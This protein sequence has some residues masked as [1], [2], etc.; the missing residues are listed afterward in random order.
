[1]NSNFISYRT[2]S[3]T[4]L[5]RRE[6]YSTELVRHNY[7]RNRRSPI[8]HEVSPSIRLGVPVAG[9]TRGK[10]SKSVTRKS[11]MVGNPFEDSTSI[12]PHAFTFNFE[13]GPGDG[14]TVIVFSDDYQNATDEAWEER[15]D[16][17]IPKSVHAIDPS[18]K[19]AL[20]F[21]L[22]KSKSAAKIGGKY[23]IRG[24]KAALRTGKGLAKESY[25]LA[26]FKA[27]QKLIESLLKLCYQKDKPKRIAA[28][29][30]LESQYPEVYKKCDFSKPSRPR[31]RTPPQLMRFPRRYV[32]EL[33]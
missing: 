2:K 28:R 17:R 11:R 3:I 13:Y 33:Y 8:E 25:T 24:T 5:S 18:I 19:E 6:D 23:A 16:K 21:V 12:G 32:G 14:E 9:Y 31:R 10:G 20:G 1:M 4:Y 26:G 29:T 27:K 30:A 7:P 22:K 15:K